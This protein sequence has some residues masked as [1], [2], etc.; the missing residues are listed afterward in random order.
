MKYSSISNCGPDI[1]KHADPNIATMYL[2]GESI[3][4]YNIYSSYN[5]IYEWV[6]FHI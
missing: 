3:H 5:Q 6:G 2:Q 1:S 4:L